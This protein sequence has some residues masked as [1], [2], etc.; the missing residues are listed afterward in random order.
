M[1]R[2]HLLRDCHVKGNR[3]CRHPRPPPPRRPIPPPSP[4]PD[5]HPRSALP[6]PPAGR[7]GSLTR[8]D[9]RAEFDRSPPRMAASWRSTQPGSFRSCRGRSAASGAAPS[10][11]TGSSSPPMTPR[12]SKSF[13]RLLKTTP[14]VAGYGRR[15]HPATEDLRTR[16]RQRLVAGRP[17]LDAPGDFLLRLVVEDAEGDDRAAPFVDVW[18]ERARKVREE[19]EGALRPA[20]EREPRYDVRRPDAPLA[21]GSRGRRSKVAIDIAGAFW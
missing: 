9:L 16:S 3:A 5:R 1:R 17:R 6:P 4:A 13:E 21:P 19:P 11:P 20:V 18:V 10:P 12:L 15:P 2:V 7:E 14:S 8:T